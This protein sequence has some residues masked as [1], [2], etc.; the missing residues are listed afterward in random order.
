MAVRNMALLGQKAQATY[1]KRAKE[2]TK[3]LFFR[4]TRIRI[5]MV[6][7]YGRIE[8]ESSNRASRAHRKINFAIYFK[9]LSHVNSSKQVISPPHSP[10]PIQN[11]YIYYN[12]N[13][14]LQS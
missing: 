5:D 7:R 11:M 14:A 10:H 4:V 13:R 1:S 12:N 9:L 8:Y 3:V 6:I 2:G